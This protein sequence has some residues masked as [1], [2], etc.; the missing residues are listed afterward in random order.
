MQIGKDSIFTVGRDGKTHYDSIHGITLH[1]PSNSL[2][3]DVE[4][5]AVTVKVGFSHHNRS[6]DMVICSATVVLQCVP[7]IMFTKDVFLKVP[8]FASSAD[9]NDLCFVKFKDDNYGEVHNGVFPVD[10]PY[11]VV[12]MRSFSSYLIVKGKST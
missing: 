10:Y 1:F 8:H 2:P 4:Q 11:G 7:Q 9:S 12:T 5:T 3:S 6:A